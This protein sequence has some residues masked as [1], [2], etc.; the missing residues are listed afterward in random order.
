MNMNKMSLALISSSLFTFVT[1]SAGAEIPQKSNNLTSSLTIGVSPLPTLIENEGGLYRTDGIAEIVSDTNFKTT[2]FQLVS[3]LSEPENREKSSI[4]IALEYLKINS[5][6]FGLSAEEISELEVTSTR[7]NEK[8]SVVRFEQRINGVSVYGSEIAVTVTYDGKVTFVASN[9]VTGL[10]KTK[11]SSAKIINMNQAIQLAKKHLGVNRLNFKK[12]DLVIYKS[13]DASQYDAWQ[14]RLTPNDGPKGDWEVIVDAVTGKILRAEN[15]E[16][17]AKG[18]AQVFKADP[19]A[20]AG[21][22]YGDIGFVDNTANSS[23]SNIKQTPTDSPE[24]TA[25]RVNVTLEDVTFKD[26]NYSLAGQ[27]AVCGDFESPQDKACPVQPQQNFDFTRTNL[28][29]DGVNA[30]YAIDSYMRYVNETLNVKVMPFQYKGGVLFDPHG[31]SG[32]DNSHYIPSA[33]KLA[34]GQG[35][36]D[37][38]EDVAV[39]IHELGHGIHDWLTHGNAGNDGQ[40]GMGEG[41]GDYLAGGYLRDVNESKWKSTDTEYNWVMRWDGH[42]PFW[43]GR[44]T[45]W[46]I[47]RTYP[48]DVVNTGSPHTAGQYWSSCNL[49]ARDRLGAKLMDAV[50]LN[51]LSKTIRSTNQKGAAQAIIDAAKDMHYSQEQIDKIAYAYNTS[52][53]YGVTVPRALE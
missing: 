24:L 52:C 3:A 35:G 14:V 32:E 44:V 38:A 17:H 37:D 23:S 11:F 40:N 13:T 43:G 27:Y 53:T 31:L 18:S 6:K 51:G 20:L 42:N 46:N 10:A 29:F 50:F 25:A 39:V 19:L 12:A 48:K 4:S 5:S 8:F 28:Y 22:K 2:N 16:L 15:K 49:D 33:G 7:L 45:N 9:T 21:K 41:T 30:Y 1:L 36:V 47:G 26:G 34:F